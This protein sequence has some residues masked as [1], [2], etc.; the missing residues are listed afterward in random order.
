M[1]LSDWVLLAMVCLAGAASPGPSLIL[2]INSVIK[3]GRKQVSRSVLP[4]DWEYSFT[5]SWLL[6][7]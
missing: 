7:D 4:M 3:D 5:L 6:L 1:A 2:L